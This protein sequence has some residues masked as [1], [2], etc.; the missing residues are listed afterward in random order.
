MWRAL[1]WIAA[2][3]PATALAQDAQL[4]GFLDG[5]LV[6]PSAD[7]AWTDGGP[8]KSRYGGGGE[9]LRFAGAALEGRWQALSSLSTF[10]DVQF[11]TD[12]RNA[13][14][15]VEAYARWRPVST[16]PWRASVKLG[17]FFPPVSLENEG[18]G[19]T[20]L[21][22]LTPSAINSWVGEELR[23]FGGEARLEH[24]GE[25]QS[26]EAAATLFE[27]TDPAGE[28][29]AARGWS[30]SDLTLGLGSR[31]REPDP[32]SPAPHR[33]NGFQELDHRL[34]WI[35][36]L[37]WRAPVS[38]RVTLL[39]YDNDANASVHGGGAEGVFAWHTYFWSLAGRTELGPVTLIAQGMDG[40][41][42]IAPPGF[43]GETQFAAGFLLAGWE[44]GRWRTA[45]RLDAFST[46]TEPPSDD[47]EHGNAVTA[48]LS[49]RAR[50]WAR[51]TAEVLR[52]DS[53]REAR[54]AGG[55]PAALVE[56]QA[57]LG[58]RLMF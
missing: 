21:W 48:A 49:L 51:L 45:L 43:H 47:S 30:L 38:G 58:V 36:E 4:Q 5:R 41:T 6:L 23:S 8:G 39:R 16:S 55:V 57:Q 1:L 13:V 9:D 7:T 18:V 52:I 22:T 42:E 11:H 10:A 46:S 29:M 34:G 24:R 56:W 28:L 27:G 2:T 37:T 15:L 35:G 3:I 50:D 40:A 25:G 26:L 53:T 19:W 54:T 33:Y 32:Y 17:E 44:S 31:T 14:E 12:D 20:S